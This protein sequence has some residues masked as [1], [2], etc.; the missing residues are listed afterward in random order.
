MPPRFIPLESKLRKAGY[1]IIAGIDEAGRGPLA[2]PLVVAAVILK[3]NARIRNLKDSKLLSEHQR[4]KLFPIIIKNS[5]EIT[6]TIIPNTLIDKINILNAVR[7]ANNQCVKYLE[8]KPDIV[9]CDG[10]DRQ[11]INVPFQN[12]IKGDRQIKSI[13]AASV[14]AKVIR[15]RL[16]KKY[17]RQYPKYEFDK[18]MGYGTRRHRGLILKHGHCEIHRKSY[19]LKDPITK[20]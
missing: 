1:K 16:M 19:N 9:L 8:L 15:D 6:V 17:A 14:I 20:E 10:K 2:G 18:H 7:I 12:I 13:A 3:N 11:L 4:E 5:I